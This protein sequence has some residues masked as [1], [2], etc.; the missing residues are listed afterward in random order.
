M[1]TLASADDATIAEQRKHADLGTDENVALGI[2]GRMGAGAGQVVEEVEDP[3]L[4][5]GRLSSVG[6]HG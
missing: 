4:I 3:V 5:P 1:E 2:V 6:G